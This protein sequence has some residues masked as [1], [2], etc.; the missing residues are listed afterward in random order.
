[1]TA[2]GLA[3]IAGAVLSLFFGYIPGFKGWFEGLETTY[4]RLVMA[5][6]LLLVSL[7]IFGLSCW[8][9]AT[10]YVTCDV[11]GFWGLAEVFVLALVANQGAFLL[12]K[13]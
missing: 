9:V 8:K 1:M 12:T 13:G 5:G 7:A 2:E 3:L 6:L 4:K 10:P 11:T